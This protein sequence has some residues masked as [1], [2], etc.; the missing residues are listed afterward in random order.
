M[1]GKVKLL[2]DLIG[3]SGLKFLNNA[4]NASDLVRHAKISESAANKFINLRNGLSGQR[5]TADTLC[6]SNYRI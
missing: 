5:L 6:L 2:G 4:E 3:E 1:A